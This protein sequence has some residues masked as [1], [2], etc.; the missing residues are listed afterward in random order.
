MR[1]NTQIVTKMRKDRTIS[2]INTPSRKLSVKKL[3]VSE[4]LTANI[5]HIEYSKIYMNTLWIDTN[6][7]VRPSTLV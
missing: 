1:Q 4:N 5:N 7:F 2:Q 6:P 3:E